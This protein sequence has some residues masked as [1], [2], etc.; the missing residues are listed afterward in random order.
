MLDDYTINMSDNLSGVFMPVDQSVG[1]S[2]LTQSKSDELYDCNVL[3][4]VFYDGANMSDDLVQYMYEF[5]ADMV[6]P[7]DDL[8]VSQL[9]LGNTQHLFAVRTPS[10]KNKFKARQGAKTVKKRERLESTS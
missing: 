8:Y 5:T 10:T 9:L 3:V 1:I 2:A 6:N 7:S 4:Q